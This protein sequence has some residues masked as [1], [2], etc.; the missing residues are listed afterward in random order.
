ME[1]GLSAGGGAGVPDIDLHHRSFERSP[2]STSVESIQVALKRTPEAIAVPEHIDELQVVVHALKLGNP[3]E[4]G[5]RVQHDGR[6]GFSLLQ[7]QS[8]WHYRQ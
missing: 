6:D 8:A 5:L 4:A 2:I 1:G 7:L 3:D